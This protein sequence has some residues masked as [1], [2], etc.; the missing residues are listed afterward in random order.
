MIG[1][2]LAHFKIVGKL[3]GGGLVEAQLAPPHIRLIHP[4]VR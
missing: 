4:G 3:G 2:T 1:S